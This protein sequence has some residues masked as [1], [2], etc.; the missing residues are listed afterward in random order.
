MGGALPS[1]KSRELQGG[2]AVRFHLQDDSG[3]RSRIESGEGEFKGGGWGVDKFVRRILR[4]PE[5][6]TRL[7]I[8]NIDDLRPRSQYIPRKEVRDYIITI[9]G[10]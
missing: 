7:T 8:C 3:R 5:P 10:S 4:I 6:M 9:L 1:L 2:D